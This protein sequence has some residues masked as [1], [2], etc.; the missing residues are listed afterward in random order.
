V[1]TFVLVAAVLV[2]VALA[3]LLPPLLR[4]ETAGATTDRVALNLALLRDQLADLEAE[5]ARGAVSSG[6]YAESKAELDRRVLE[7]TTS[8]ERAA[9]AW[10]GAGRATAAVVAGIVP[11]AAVVLYLVLGDPS[12]FDLQRRAQSMGDHTKQP[13][14]QDIEAM[15]SKLAQ[16]LEKEPENA[17]GWAMLARSYY[18][19]QRYP[20]AVRAYEKLLALV[21]QEPAVLADYAD[22]LAMK[23]GRKIAGKPLE[24]VQMALKIDPAQPKALAMAGTEAFD[25]QDFKLAVQYWEK[26]RASVPPDSEMAQNIEGSIAEARQRGNIATAD[27]PAATPKSQSPAPAKPAPAAAGVSVQGTVKVDPAVAAKA[28]PTDTVF[29]F[30]RA[31]EGPRV[32]LAVFKL[33]AKDLPAKFVLDDSLAMAPQ[34]KLSN[35]K[36][37]LVNARISKSGS[38]TPSAGD[39]EGKGVPVNVGARDVVI[40]I[41][42][43]VP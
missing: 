22:A 16:R 42:R 35:F 9:G 25:R 20:D 17:D 7:E 6:H 37:V 43:V 14:S 10:A 26:L 30:A 34:F 40:T 36:D 23:N 4:R 33:Q 5:H 21:P 15:L 28:A 39:L 18:V 27:V 3:W 1:I 12:A 38:A 13:T 29:V 2:A 24:L 19:L 31:A 11:S 32:P 8:E 41:D